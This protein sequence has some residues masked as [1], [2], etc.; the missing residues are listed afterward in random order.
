[1]VNDVC[2]NLQRLQPR[3]WCNT[4]AML[5][6]T[7]LP[8]LFKPDS[9]QLQTSNQLEMVETSVAPACVPQSCGAV[10]TSSHRPASVV[11]DSHVIDPAC[12]ASQHTANSNTH[13]FMCKSPSCIE[14]A[15]LITGVQ[16]YAPLLQSQSVDDFWTVYNHRGSFTNMRVSTTLGQ[17]IQTQQ[18]V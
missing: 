2:A 7:P 16:V 5:R 3:C 18:H 14:H 6:A 9:D 10:T 8:V 15:T 4:H 17:H 1:V 11:G 13:I 12:V